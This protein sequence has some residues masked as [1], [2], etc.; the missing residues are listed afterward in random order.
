VNNL[1]QSD[2][3][4]PGVALAGHRAA[5]GRCGARLPG[6]ARDRAAGR[7]EQ[8]QNGHDATFADI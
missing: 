6:A 5:I 2:R 3:C 8:L 7:R 4:Y 1:Q